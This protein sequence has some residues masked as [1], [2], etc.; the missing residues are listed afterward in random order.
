[1]EW[2]N[3]EKNFFNTLNSPIKIQEFLDN[4]NYDPLEGSVSPRYVIKELKANCFEGAVFAAAAL[5]NIGY[6]PL[7]LDLVAD[8]DD[9]HVIAVYKWNNHWG[10]IAKSNTTVLRY[11]EPVYKNIRELVMSYFD[12]YLNTNGEKTLRQYSEPVDLKLFNDANWRTT[13]K[14]LEFIS[15]YLYSIKHHNILDKRM[16][17]NLKKADKLLLE[18]TLLG[19]IPDGLYKP[20]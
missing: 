11:R 20:E 7:I 18:A 2:T 6:K 5:E 8:N 13:D 15:D 1:M 4:I 17:K 14:D 19:S 9:D 10:A 3:A 12:F 16:I